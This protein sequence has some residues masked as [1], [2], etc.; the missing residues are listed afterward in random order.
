MRE[1]Q[2]P[3]EEFPV[4]F[5]LVVLSDRLECDGLTPLS[6]QGQKPVTG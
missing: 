2:N 6:I 1:N 5:L 3:V 4:S